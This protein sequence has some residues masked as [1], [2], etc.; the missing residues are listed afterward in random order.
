MSTL[1]SPLAGFALAVS[2]AASVGCVN[3]AFAGEVRGIV[4][5]GPMC[6][7]PA[8]IGTKCPSKPIA[9]TIDIF[10]NPNDLSNSSKAY[11]RIKSD[12]QG[13]FRIS[14]APGTYWFM[15]HGRLGGISSAKPQEV[16]VTAGTSTITLVVDTGMR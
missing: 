14:L 9:S 13:H 2:F 16:A 8:H 6:P 7:G 3:S 4:V 1:H 12:T 15:A 5:L 11:R 10:R